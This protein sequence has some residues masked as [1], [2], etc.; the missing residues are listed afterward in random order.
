MLQ[1]IIQLQTELDNSFHEVVK[2]V[3]DP[4]LH[5]GT[6]DYAPLVVNPK[7]WEELPQHLKDVVIV[8]RDRARFS[9][10]MIL[11]DEMKAREKWKAM[12]GME[13]IRWSDKDLKDARALG[14]KMILDES[15]KSAE[16]KEFVKIYS[17]TL[18]E[19]GYKDEAKVLGYK[20]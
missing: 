4:A 17:K 2:Y 20:K 3:V 18:F 5:N 7:K 11:V 9:S 13:I 16:G 8:A 1:D 10:A 6:C 19:L 14:M 15:N 12:P